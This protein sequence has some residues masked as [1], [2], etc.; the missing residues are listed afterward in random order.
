MKIKANIAGSG[1][2]N[3]TSFAELAKQLKESQQ[4][5]RS[6]DISNVEKFGDSLLADQNIT[7]YITMSN[8]QQVGFQVLDSVE[9]PAYQAWE[10]LLPEECT[11]CVRTV[12][13]VD[14]YWPEWVEQQVD[15]LESV[16]D[17]PGTHL[18][19]SKV[20][21]LHDGRFAMQ[22]KSGEALVFEGDQCRFW[23]SS[24]TCDFKGVEVIY[25]G[26][27]LLITADSS[28]ELISTHTAE[29]DYLD[30]LCLQPA[31][32]AKTAI[33]CLKTLAGKGSQAI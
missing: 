13:L 33:N 4:K 20:A 1:E 15:R 27:V 16:Y 5:S 25:H 11:T 17:L 14:L 12:S 26:H 30:R 3:V 29:A 22:S 32:D 7:R 31:L 9:F 6:E 24:S 23:V 2:L 19:V 18:M 21:R 28:F 8:K 10:A